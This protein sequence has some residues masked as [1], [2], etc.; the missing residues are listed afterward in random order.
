MT[1]LVQCY[2][3]EISFPRRLLEELQQAQA[4]A[5]NFKPKPSELTL[6]IRRTFGFDIRS[7]IDMNVLT[8]KGNK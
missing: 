8:P 5:Q 3:F 6:F 1:Y 4:E 2:G 7:Y